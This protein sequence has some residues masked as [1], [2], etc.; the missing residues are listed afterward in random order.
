VAAFA[1][2]FVLL[3]FVVVGLSLFK[4]VLICS[5][6]LGL[7]L[8]RVVGDVQLQRQRN[9]CANEAQGDKRVVLSIYPIFLPLKLEYVVASVPGE[10]FHAIDYG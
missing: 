2:A 1:S 3:V 4:V 10:S 5:H 8:S 6:V 7:G 9:V